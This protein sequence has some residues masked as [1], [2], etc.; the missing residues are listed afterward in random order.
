[1]PS[2][3][4]ASPHPF[5]SPQPSPQILELGVWEQALANAVA[6]RVAYLLSSQPRHVDLVDAAAVANALNVSRDWVYAHAAELGGRRIGQGNR[7]RLRFDLDYVLD[8]WRS[9]ESTGPRGA[10]QR[11]RRAATQRAQSDSGAFGRRATPDSP[12][13]RTEATDGASVSVRTASYIEDGARGGCTPGHRG[14]ESSDLPGR[15]ARYQARRAS[16]PV[17]LSRG[18]SN[19]GGTDMTRDT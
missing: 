1:M 16:R 4:M 3:P 12:T 7:G 14:T 10:V 2:T 19:Q 15:G 13:Q 17:D 6:D 8:T 11:P 9:S 5:D 18:A